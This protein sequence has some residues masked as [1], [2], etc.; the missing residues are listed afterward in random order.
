[1]TTSSLIWFYMQLINIGKI[2]VARGQ[3]ETKYPENLGRF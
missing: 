3:Q 1:M 2:D